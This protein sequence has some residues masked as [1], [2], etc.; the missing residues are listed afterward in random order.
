[1]ESETKDVDKAVREW[2]AAR[3]GKVYLDRVLRLRWQ[4]FDHEVHHG[5]V[6]FRLVGAREGR[7]ARLQLNRP[8]RHALAGECSLD[9]QLAPEQCVRLLDSFFESAIAHYERELRDTTA[10][11]QG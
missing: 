9:A 6:E 3:Q 11:M 2:M 10:E 4:P 5:R 8:L 1:M 7:D